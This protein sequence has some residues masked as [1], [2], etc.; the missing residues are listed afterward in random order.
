M[1][2]EFISTVQPKLSDLSQSQFYLNQFFTLVIQLSNPFQD[3][4][5]ANN[6][7]KLAVPSDTLTSWFFLLDDSESRWLKS[8]PQ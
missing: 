7:L 3:S 4:S 1:I 2:E 6:Q 5:Q 8:S